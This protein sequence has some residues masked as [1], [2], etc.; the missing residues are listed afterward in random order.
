MQC[1]CSAPPSPVP[2]FSIDIIPIPFVQL[3]V[4][5]PDYLVGFLS[6]SSPRPHRL[7]RLL[8]A[9]RVAVRVRED[10][11]RRRRA[12]RVASD[13]GAEAGVA[14]LA[15]AEGADVVFACEIIVSTLI[16]GD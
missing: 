6:L 10:A 2:T 8:R 7:L 4:R 5:G 16:V 13:G 14:A 11:R 15:A 12:V 3:R 9:E 1:K